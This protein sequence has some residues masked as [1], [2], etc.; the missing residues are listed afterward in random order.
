MKKIGR[1]KYSDVFE[2]IDTKTDKK[3]V[4]KMLKPSI[5]FVISHS[6]QSVQKKS[7]E[8]SK[9]CKISKGVLIL[10]S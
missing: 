1:G 10:Y 9:F 5:S 3:I 4:L 2:G 7:K 6:L 8:K